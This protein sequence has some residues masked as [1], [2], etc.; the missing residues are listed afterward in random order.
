PFFTFE[1]KTVTLLQGYPGMV[2]GDFVTLLTG[3]IDD[4]ESSN[5]NLEYV[6]SCPDIRLD[7]AQTIYRVGDDGFSTSTA[8]PRTLLAHPLDI[9]LTALET[10]CG[11]SSAQVDEAK[12]VAYRDG[13]YS[14]QSM[15]FSLTS[16]PIAKDFIESEILKPLGA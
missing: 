4:V 7:L 5:N 13:V 11:Y 12:I 2:L 8:H 1:G 10:Q 15:K 16:A 9:L 6:F 14:G 3:R